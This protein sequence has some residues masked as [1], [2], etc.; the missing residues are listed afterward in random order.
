M[1]Q[2]QQ[3][4]LKMDPTIFAIV[5]S[6]I[7]AARHSLLRPPFA[8]FTLALSGLMEKPVK[9]M[10]Y[11]SRITDTNKSRFHDLGTLPYLLKAPAL[12]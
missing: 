12:E 5:L 3:W 9:F 1:K 11:W 2:G 8:S 4:I 10:L 6:S 7:W